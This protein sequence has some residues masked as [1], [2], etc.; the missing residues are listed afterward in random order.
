VTLSRRNVTV[1][2]YRVNQ[3]HECQPIQQNVWHQSRNDAW[4]NVLL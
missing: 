4:N 2:L 1:A 3:C